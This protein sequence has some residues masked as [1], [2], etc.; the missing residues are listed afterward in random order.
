[1]GSLLIILFCLFI[2]FIP[3]IN[4]ASNKHKNGTPIFIINLLLGWTFVGWV[5]ALAWSCTKK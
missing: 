5:V 1:M 3:T 4:A 2:Y